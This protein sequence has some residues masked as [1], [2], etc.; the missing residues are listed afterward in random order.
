MNISS[1]SSGE[2]AISGG[3]FKD[4]LEIAPENT[5]NELEKIT[6][7]ASLSS[8]LPRL[9]GI[10]DAIQKPD[11]NVIDGISDNIGRLQD[12]FVESVYGLAGSAGVDLGQKLT[13][14]LDENDSLRVVGEHP[15]KESMNALL[16]SRPDI[17]T[18]FKEI[19]TQSELLRNVRSIGK[20][21]GSETGL[22]AYES[23]RAA[24]A[25]SS[26]QFSLKGDMSHFY[27]AK[28]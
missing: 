11:G 21:I 13:L 24:S 6:D 25:Q 2:N 1:V 8:L 19:S 4:S 3:K 22:P 26:Y 7:T 10:M 28:S 15:S 27:F 16:E 12:A 20:I 14:R 9:Q 23:M 5:N 17:S 18:A